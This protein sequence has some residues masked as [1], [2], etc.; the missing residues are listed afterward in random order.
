MS[1]HGYVKSQNLGCAKNTGESFSWV[2]TV[3]VTICYAGVLAEWHTRQAEGEEHPARCRWGGGAA[4]DARRSRRRHPRQPRKVRAARS[5]THTHTHTRARARTETR[6]VAILASQPQREKHYMTWS[7]QKVSTGQQFVGYHNHRKNGTLMGL[8]WM[9][10][11]GWWEERNT[12]LKT[13][14]LLKVW[15]GSSTGT[16]HS[17]QRPECEGRQESPQA[18]SW[19]TA[20][21][22]GTVEQ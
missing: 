9:Q 18:D 8:V 14:N 15:Q 5:H 13:I 22:C 1:L 21:N 19:R 3:H 20:S 4:Q 10:K 12:T 16:S 6:A 2:I 7:L 17:G 11:D